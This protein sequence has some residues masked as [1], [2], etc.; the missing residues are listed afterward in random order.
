MRAEIL[1][2]AFQRIAYTLEGVGKTSLLA[3]Y[4][5]YAFGECKVPGDSEQGVGVNSFVDWA[6]IS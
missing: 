4:H 5:D 3:M 6:N 1:S 2:M